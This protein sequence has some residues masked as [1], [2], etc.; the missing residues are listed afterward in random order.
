[1][2]TRTR[3]L[4]AAVMT[5]ALIVTGC[6]SGGSTSQTQLTCVAAELLTQRKCAIE[7]NS[8]RCFYAQTVAQLLCGK[9]AMMTSASLLAPELDDASSSSSTLSGS[10]YSPRGLTVYYRSFPGGPEVSTTGN[11]SADPWAIACSGKLGANLTACLQSRFFTSSP[12]VCA[13]YSRAFGVV[14]CGSPAGGWSRGPSNERWGSAKNALNYFCENDPTIIGSTGRAGGWDC[15]STAVEWA[16][17]GAFGGESIVTEWQRR[18]V[19]PLD[20]PVS[21]CGDGRADSG[22]TCVNCPADLGVC[23]P[24]PSSDDKVDCAVLKLPAPGSPLYVAYRAGVD[25]TGSVSTALT[26]CRVGGSLP[27][28][29][30]TPALC[31]PANIQ[32]ALCGCVG[33]TRVER[34]KDQCR[35]GCAWAK[36]SELCAGS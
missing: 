28:P 13:E 3:V 9:Q 11:P 35:A 32:A 16:R 6:A 36:E 7:P 29:T 5:L 10:G 30:P 12:A 19:P 15:E 20:P 33:W 27:V 1:M 4:T 21:R 31:V 18:T 22:E 26:E 23:P 8:D 34:R 2:R 14:T 17:L 25:S 24:L